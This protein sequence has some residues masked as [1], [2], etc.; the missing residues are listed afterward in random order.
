MRKT[1][2]LLTILICFFANSALYAQTQKT[3]SLKDGS[4]IIGEVIQLKDGVYT[5]KTSLLGEIEVKDEDILTISI[6]AESSSSNSLKNQVQQIQGDILNDE[7]IMEDIQNVM[8]D[9]EIMKLLSNPDLINDVMTF[10]EDKIRANE[11]ISDLMANPEIQNL[12]NKI[13]QKIDINE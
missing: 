6:A 11:S 8:Q 5:I 7:E 13:N 12:I 10:N 3:I 9:K 1:I 4:T 2:A